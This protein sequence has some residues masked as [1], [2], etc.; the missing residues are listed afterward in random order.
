[1]N[2]FTRYSRQNNRNA[3]SNIVL[4]E[5]EQERRDV[6]RNWE[7]VFYCSNVSQICTGCYTYRIPSNNS[8]LYCLHINRCVFDQICTYQKLSCDICGAEITFTKCQLEHHF[9]NGNNHHVKIKSHQFGTMSRGIGHYQGVT[10]EDLI[11]A[12]NSGAYMY[13]LNLNNTLRANPV[14]QTNHG[15]WANLGS[16]TL[17]ITPTTNSGQVLPDSPESPPPLNLQMLTVSRCERNT[18]P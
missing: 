10:R 14:P 6:I 16:S 4:L 5:Q 17:T 18:L 15:N 1:M 9:T 3:S 7:R 8:V 11:E 13:A 12:R 2:G